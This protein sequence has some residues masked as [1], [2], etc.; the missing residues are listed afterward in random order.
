MGEL[1]PQEIYVCFKITLDVIAI[2]V[3]TE[4]PACWV[5]IHTHATA[6]QIIQEHAAVVH[7]SCFINAHAIVLYYVKTECFYTLLTTIVTTSC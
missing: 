3:S 4:V 5:Q 6:C 7:T 2:H 1:I